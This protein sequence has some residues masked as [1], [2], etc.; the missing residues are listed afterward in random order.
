MHAYVTSSTTTSGTDETS[1]LS[2]SILNVDT[3][4]SLFMKHS[5]LFKEHLTTQESNRKGT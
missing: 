1:T 4:I 5:N 2:S 3:I